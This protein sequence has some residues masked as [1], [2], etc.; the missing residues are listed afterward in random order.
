MSMEKAYAQALWKLVENGM[1]PGKAVRSIHAQ[2]QSR[3]RTPL[4]PRIARAFKRLAERES[5]KNDMVLSVA[6]EKDERRAR[7]EAKAFLAGRGITADMNI[8]IDDSVIGGWR[9][10]GRGLLVDNTYRNRL[11]TIYKRATRT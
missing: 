4:M 10:E 9:L 5:R 6:R 2:L 7:S 3:G 8:R 1:A 11:L